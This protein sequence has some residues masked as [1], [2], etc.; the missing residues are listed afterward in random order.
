M[1]IQLR[2]I[3]G[4]RNQFDPGGSGGGGGPPSPHGP[5]HVSNGTDPI[6]GATSSAGGLMSAAD[7]VKLDAIAASA[8][9]GVTTQEEGATVGTLQT[10]LNWIGPATTVASVGQT[11]TITTVA[12]DPLTTQLNGVDV[13]TF[14]DT[15]NFTTG[16]NV[17]ALGGT[18]TIAL[19]NTAVTPGVYGSGSAVPVITVDQQGRITLASTAAISGTDVLVK[20]SAA[21]TTA[22]YL[23]NKIVAGSNVTI[24]KLNPGANEQL[25]ITASGGG[26]GSSN[27]Y[28]PAG[29]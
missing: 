2:T 5:T 24:T 17:T 3:L 7:K 20:I 25:R 28:N 27:S 4:F 13:G 11:T 23:E 19:A 9:N 15:L 14:Q 12:T 10:I 18:S 16:M 21:D 6:P 29:W 1:A 8:T 26:G 22:N